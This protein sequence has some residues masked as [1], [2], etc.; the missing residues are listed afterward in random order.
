MRTPY[1][2]ESAPEDAAI[3]P[4]TEEPAEGGGAGEE[5]APAAVQT[6]SEEEFPTEGPRIELDRFSGPFEVLLYL[7]KSQ[8]ID[9]FDIPILKVTEQYLQFIDKMREQ[10]LEVAGDFLVMAATLIHI[11]SKMILPIE[12][13]EEEEEEFE[14]E[15]PRLD[16]V[17]KLLEYRKFRD[18][19]ALLGDRA[20]VAKDCFARSA[21]PK[22]EA[23]EDDDEVDLE[24]GLYDL[25]EAIR[26]I[27]RFLTEKT[28]HEVIGEGASVEEKITHIEALLEIRDSVEWR[29]LYKECASRVE[30]VC[31]FLAILE[32]CRMGRI[33]A[34]QHHTYGNIRIFA[35][36]TGEEPLPPPALEESVPPVPVQTASEPVSDAD[37][38]I[39]PDGWRR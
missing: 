12:L 14:E 31:C 18:L 2:S 28:A 17:E 24:V 36:K 9:I 26:G 15:D 7:I 11:K 23:G 34:H 8:E 19:A 22:I 16:L 21:K 20:E 13:E 6:F 10:N 5:T 1:L 30:L 35:L 3:D 25:T 38:A 32:L 33:R 4:C 39:P 37:D 29:E 27:L